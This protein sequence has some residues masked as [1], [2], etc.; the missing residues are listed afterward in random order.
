MQLQRWIKVAVKWSCSAIWKR[1]NKAHGC[2]SLVI[3]SIEH[4]GAMKMK[5][6][7]WIQLKKWLWKALNTHCKLEANRMQNALLSSVNM[8]NVTVYF[9][10]VWLVLVYASSHLSSINS[11]LCLFCRPDWV[12]TASRGIVVSSSGGVGLLVIDML[13]KTK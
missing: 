5:W 4:M 1:K 8:L 2:L 12:A 6:K 11:M 9:I 3:S 10:L 7:K 13:F